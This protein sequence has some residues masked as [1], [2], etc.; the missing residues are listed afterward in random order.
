MKVEDA[1]PINLQR[2]LDH[3]LIGSR[4]LSQTAVQL[5][6]RRARQRQRRRAADAIDRSIVEHQRD[7]LRRS[8]QARNA[9]ARRAPVHLQRRRL[10]TLGQRRRRGELR[11]QQFRGVDLRHHQ[12]LAEL[13]RHRRC[14][15]ALRRLCHQRDT[16]ALTGHLEPEREARDMSLPRNRCPLSGDML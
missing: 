11:N 5:Q 13:R 12:D 6:M 2:R 16:G 7:P 10:A 9:A 3:R 1:S 8:G 14:G 15:G 4:I